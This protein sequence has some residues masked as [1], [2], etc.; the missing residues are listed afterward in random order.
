VVRGPSVG[1]PAAA[2]PAA[3]DTSRLKT[4]SEVSGIERPPKP[5][6]NNSALGSA[7]IAAPTQPRPVKHVSRSVP[8]P[9]R[10]R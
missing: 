5:P 3:I 1:A 7:A 6:V 9:S 8:E 10:S 2:K 4:A